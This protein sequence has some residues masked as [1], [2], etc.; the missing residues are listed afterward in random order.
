MRRFRFTLERVLELRRYKERE[1][2]LKLAKI[3]GI[4]FTIERRISEI[5]TQIKNTIQ[6]LFRSDMIG[7][8]S[9]L[10]S[11]EFYMTRLRQ[12]RRDKEEELKK[13]IDERQAIQIEYLVHSRKRKVLEKLKEKREKE[14]Y[15]LVNKE[16]FKITDDINN[17]IFFRKEK[18]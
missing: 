1:W 9:Y 13:R 2:E 7:D 3:T 8:Y 12:E 18:E 11:N 17:G 14:Y 5:D 4:C 16:E 6:S 15:S 10:V